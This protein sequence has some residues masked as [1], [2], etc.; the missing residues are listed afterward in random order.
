MY[1][2]PQGS[3]LGPLLFLLYINDI[4]NASNLGHFILFADDTN[5]FITGKTEKEVY[6]HANQVLRAVSDYMESNLLHINISKS[7][8]MLFRPNRQSSRARAREYN[9][10]QSLKLSDIELTR[11]EHVRFLGVIIDSGLSWE[12]HLEKLQA[13]L[14]SSIAIIKRI[15]KFI[16]KTECKKL[17][18]S[19]F[20]SHLSY[21]ISCWGGVTP[22]CIILF[23]PV[24]RFLQLY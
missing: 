12:P 9:C 1:G 19:L 5:I 23:I 15:M 11:V 17:Y 20:K 6:S 3:V 21:C 18:D 13:K 2:V 24:P 4:T 8:Y 10:K 22:Y 14:A 16:P 7:V